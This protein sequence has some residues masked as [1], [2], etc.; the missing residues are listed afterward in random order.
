MT[1]RT[2]TRTFSTTQVD[3]RMARRERGDPGRALL[4]LV[5]SHQ[6]ADCLGQ[7]QISDQRQLV[8]DPRCR[9]DVLLGRRRRAENQVSQPQLEAT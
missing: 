5:C 9:A 7:R 6:L 4:A 3:H 2:N 8:G 1:I